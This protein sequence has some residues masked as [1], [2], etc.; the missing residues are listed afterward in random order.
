[1][2]IATNDGS[3]YYMDGE[4]VTF[5]IGNITFPVSEARGLVTPFSIVGTSDV[6]NAQVI[7][8]ARLLQTLD[9][10]TDLSDGIQIPD[11]SKSPDLAI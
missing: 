3:Y 1:M 2:T 7:N 8:I 10:N 11:F 4:S 5:S 6:E 9:A